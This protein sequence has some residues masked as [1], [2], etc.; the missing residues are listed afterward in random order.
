MYICT[1][2][3]RR[4]HQP[5]T[6][7]ENTL[8]ALPTLANNSKYLI[9]Y[10]YRDPTL[11]CSGSIQSRDDAVTYLGPHVQ[12]DYWIRESGC[13]GCAINDEI[14]WDGGSVMNRVGFLGSAWRG[15][16]GYACVGCSSFQTQIASC[17]SLR[18]V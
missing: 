9:R 2:A 11:K 16:K 15:M 4:A 1:V 12:P 7:L 14:V 3:V 6:G 18:T 17:L 13:V 5:A 8:Q 10:T